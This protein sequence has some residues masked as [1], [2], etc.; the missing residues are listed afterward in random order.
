ML[1]IKFYFLIIIFF[2]KIKIILKL[3]NIKY[4]TVIIHDGKKDQ[5][6]KY[7][8]KFKERIVCINNLIDTQ[9]DII[10][11]VCK[12]INLNYSNECLDFMSDRQYNNKYMPFKSYIQLHFD[13]KWIHDYYIKKYINIEP[14]EKDLI[15]FINAIISRDKNLIITTGKYPS[16]KLENIMDKINNKK[17]KI[18]KDQSLQE[19]ENIVFNCDLL[20]TCHGWISHIAS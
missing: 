8:L 12:K 13:E 1:L 18:F 7:F 17:V 15:N 5:N 16:L 3:R 19:L 9:L 14:S 10:K 2:E 6:L 20:I 4:D 11:I